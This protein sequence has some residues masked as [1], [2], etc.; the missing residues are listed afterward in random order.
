M[1]YSILT[2]MT[3]T[4]I[5]VCIA[6]F[7]KILRCI[8]SRWFPYMHT[9]IQI[10]NSFL[11]NGCHDLSMAMIFL[12]YIYWYTSKQM[13]PN[14]RF[15]TAAYACGSSLQS[16]SVVN[17]LISYCTVVH[18]F[19]ITIQCITKDRSCKC[20]KSKELGKK[21]QLNL[22]RTVKLLVNTSWSVTVHF[23]SIQ[24]CL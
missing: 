12:V 5:S 1:I 17:T 23:L 24:C 9:C 4:I 8:L 20:M 3:T 14:F 11:R 6:N 2:A 18:F 19:D 13:F 16:N 21:I 10:W 15:T 22:K 7:T